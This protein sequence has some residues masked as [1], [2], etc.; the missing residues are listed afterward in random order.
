MAIAINGDGT[1]T[2]LAAGGLPDASVTA[3]DLASGLANQKITEVDEWR[4]TSNFSRSGTDDITSN[5]ERADTV[6][7]KIGTGMTESSG[8]F[9]FPSTGIWLID[10]Q[11]NTFSQ[12]GLSS[13]IELTCAY[14]T[15]GGSSYATDK[16]Y[17]YDHVEYQMGYYAYNTQ[18]TQGIIDVTDTSNWRVKFRVGAGN[19]ATNF[20]GSS[21]HKGNNFRF[22]RLGDT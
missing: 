10:M 6:F 3:A 7:S 17:S 8:I 2:G 11:I 15:N 20:L 18:M 1:I 12:T 22:I 19:N 4:F 14:S 16:I 21:S 9:T 5:W 13:W